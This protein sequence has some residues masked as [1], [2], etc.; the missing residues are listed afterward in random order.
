MILWSLICRKMAI[1]VC[2]TTLKNI[3]Y[4]FHLQGGIFWS[5]RNL[6]H[7]LDMFLEILDFKVEKIKN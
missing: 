1:I 5:L 2:K 7:N 4:R 3:I 6:S